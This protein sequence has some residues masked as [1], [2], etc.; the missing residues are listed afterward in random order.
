MPGMGCG[1]EF[2]SSLIDR[3]LNALHYPVAR[4][5]AHYYGDYED[6]IA[7]FLRMIMRHSKPDW[8][9]VD[10]GCG[11]ATSVTPWRE[12]CRRLIGIDISPRIRENSWVGYRVR[13][14][15]YQLPLV[16]NSV[17]LVIMRYV[18]EHL[19]RPVDALREAALV[20]CPGG[21]LVLLTPNRY[22]YVCMVARLTPHWF[23]RWFLA[24]H[25]RFEGDVS[26]TRYRANT[27]RHLREVASRA[28]F[29]ITELELYEAQPGYLG[30]F[31]PAFMLGV[32]Y[33]R[34]VNRFECLAGLRVS[35]LATFEKLSG[36]ASPVNG[37]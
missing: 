29:R 23:H 31:W 17:D 13:G 9:V 12:F 20:L 36:G 10:L 14:D 22:H 4:A 33:E 8:V 34:L 1:E 35:M 7:H 37:E 19:E 28:G 32:A 27:P 6:E 5:R 25:G 18:M 3:F 21:K 30:W 2:G 24:R 11:R 16:G 26:P 15:L